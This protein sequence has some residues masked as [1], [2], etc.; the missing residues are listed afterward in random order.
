MSRRPKGEGSFPKK[1]RADGR[2]AFVADLGIDETG[3]RKRRTIY[4]RSRAEL[5]R[6]VHDERARQGGSIQ[7]IAKGTVAEYIE[8]WLAETIEPNRASSTFTLY[9]GLLRKHVLPLVTAAKLE[10]FDADAVDRLY[11]RMRANGA[12]DSVMN[13]CGRI[14]RAAFE[15]RSKR[16]RTPNPFRIAEVPRYQ[17]GEVRPL[18]VNQARSFLKAA[19][20]TPIESLFVLALVA[21]LRLGEGLALRWSDID[22]VNRTVSVERALRDVKGHVT[23]ERTKTQR[24]RRRLPLNALAIAALERRRKTAEKEGHGSEYVHS[25]P[26]GAFLRPSYVRRI[27]FAPILKQAGIEGATIHSL[28]H[29]FST[30][31]GA[32]GVAPRANSDLMGHSRPSVALDIYQHSDEPAH[33]AAV[34]LLNDVL[35]GQKRKAV[36]RHR[37]GRK[38]R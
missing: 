21:G 27:Y 12:T 38:A 34:D 35:T 20:G 26:T 8:A 10:H 19:E 1:A 23:I 15:A 22:E 30:Q 6:K 17:A 7:K 29:S 16:T 18:D 32:A 28:R 31:L 33:R 25:G 5:Q 24:S 36:Q 37:K 2:W 13:S 11:A 14:L 9:D 4:A 3:N